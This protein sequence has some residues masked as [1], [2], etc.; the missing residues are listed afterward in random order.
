MCFKIVKLDQGSNCISLKVKRVPEKLLSESS[1]TMEQGG[2]LDQDQDQNKDILI[3]VKLT[4]YK[5]G[6]G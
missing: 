4:V 3:A 1:E 5:M 2:Q 6:E